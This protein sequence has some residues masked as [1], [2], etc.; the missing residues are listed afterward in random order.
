MDLS[1]TYNS[2]GVL[3]LPA[4]LSCR[5]SADEIRQRGATLGPSGVSTSSA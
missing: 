4:L 2:Q 5:S 1:N 3:L